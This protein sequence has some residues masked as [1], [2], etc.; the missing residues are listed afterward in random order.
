MIEISIII[1][2]ADTLEVVASFIPGIIQ[3][4]SNNYNTQ[5]IFV[6]AFERADVRAYVVEQGFVYSFTNKARRSI[7][8]NAGAKIASGK[9]YFFLHIDSIVP[10]H[11]DVLI[12]QSVYKGFEAGCFR[13]K[14]DSDSRFLA[15][16]A[17]F[18]QFKW[19]IA[20]G[21]DQG[22]YVRREAF[23][24]IGGYKN[25]WQIMEDVDIAGKLLK[26]KKFDIL[27]PP[28]ITSTRKYER[29]GVFKLQFL[30]AIITLFYWMGISNKTIYEFYRKYVGEEPAQM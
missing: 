28:I 2:C 22:L 4:L 7:Q 24:E 1:P 8:C 21:G 20:R 29:V 26:R 19:T 23:E 12:M 25:A 11:F 15:G 14:F 9:I 17:W 18:N 16:F 3:N 27:K 13:L 6:D 5:I 10:S 30:F